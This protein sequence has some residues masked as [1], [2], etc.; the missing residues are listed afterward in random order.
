ML[1][2]G[3]LDSLRVYP[4][5]VELDVDVV[6]HAD[7]VLMSVHQM[8]H[9]VQPTRGIHICQFCVL[10]EPESTFTEKPGS[11]ACMMLPGQDGVMFLTHLLLPHYI[12]AHWY[13]PPES[14]QEALWDYRD[15]DPTPFESM[16]GIYPA[17]TV[18]G[19]RVE[20]ERLDRRLALMGASDVSVA[21]EALRQ[22]AVE[23][24]REIEQ[25]R[26]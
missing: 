14:F 2:V 4:R 22:E 16:A 7:R 25:P 10:T 11:S 13:R 18:E 12:K 17:N 19:L 3:W 24:L 21:F 15:F 23:R 1:A 9:F 6:H 5:F 26:R 20:I 8:N